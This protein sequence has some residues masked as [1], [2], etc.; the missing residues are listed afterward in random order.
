[1]CVPGLPTGSASPQY[2]TSTCTMTFRSLRGAG[3]NREGNTSSQ[4]TVG[5]RMAWHAELGL[6]ACLL[7]AVGWEVRLSLLGPALPSLPARLGRVGSVSDVTTSH[8]R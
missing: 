6:L 4:A 1:M 3:S 2:H 5:E 7:S 8:W